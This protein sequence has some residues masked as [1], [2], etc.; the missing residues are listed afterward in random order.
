M[1]PRK[2]TKFEAQMTSSM[3]DVSKKLDGFDALLN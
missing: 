2:P 1:K 3:D